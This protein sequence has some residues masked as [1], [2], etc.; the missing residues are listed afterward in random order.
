MEA[1]PSGRELRAREQSLPLEEEMASTLRARPP[2]PPIN[3]VLVEE[4]DPAADDEDGDEG[5]LGRAGVLGWSCAE[6]ARRFSR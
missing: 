4:D 3:Q 1:L 5:R 2:S 6:P